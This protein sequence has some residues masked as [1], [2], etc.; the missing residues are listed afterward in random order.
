MHTGA[1][2][3]GGVDGVV[4]GR[5]LAGVLGGVLGDAVALGVGAGEDD[6]GPDPD[7]PGVGAAVVVDGVAEADDAAVDGPAEAELPEAVVSPVGLGEHALR[8]RAT[9]VIP[10]TTADVDLIDVMGPVFCSVL[11]GST[12]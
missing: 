11:P 3:A 7:A 6:A 2:P 5:G 4:V 10:S 9:A 12:T 1:L 8:V